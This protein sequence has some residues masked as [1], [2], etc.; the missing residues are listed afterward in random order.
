MPA[1]T[2]S[3]KTNTAKNKKKARKPTKRQVERN[4]DRILAEREAVQPKR[5]R[6]LR[7][8]HCW[9]K[10]RDDDLVLVWGEWRCLKCRRLWYVFTVH[11]DFNE[12]AVAKDVRR[13]AAINDVPILEVFV[14]KKLVEEYG[15]TTWR[16]WRDEQSRKDGWK[17]PEDLD[18]RQTLA[19]EY[20]MLGFITAETEEQAR[21]YARR[22]WPNDFQR[23]VELHKAG[24]KPRLV[25]R[26]KYKGYVA[27]KAE[28]TDDVHHLV[29][30][31]KGVLGVLPAKIGL[32]GFR[33]PRKEPRQKV[34]PKPWEI[35]LWEKWTPTPMDSPEEVEQMLA[36]KEE[37]KN[38]PRKAEY[39]FAPGEQVRIVNGQWQGLVGTVQEVSHENPVKFVVE[40]VTL[41]RT[42]RSKHEGWQLTKH[43]EN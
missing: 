17:V 39:K 12:N 37:V 19:E 27:F 11:P 6:H 33:F 10:F 9:D 1:K 8:D 13:R 21:N 34:K 5:Q 25:A 38:T 28:Y 7:C 2:K 15:K 16:V 42:F 40:I 30:G 24:G 43:E 20:G 22:K 4:L 29:H 3:Q 23:V 14:P 36:E 41:G 35:E 32:R 31:T 18:D 26:P